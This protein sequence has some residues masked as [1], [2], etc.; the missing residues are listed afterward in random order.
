MIF[1]QIRGT[2]GGETFWDLNFRRAF[3]GWEVGELQRL[4]V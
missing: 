4:L 2:Q 1:Q 3:N